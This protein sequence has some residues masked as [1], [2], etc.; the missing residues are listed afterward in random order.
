MKGISITDMA[1]NTKLNWSTK[2]NP[3]MIKAAI[4]TWGKLAPPTILRWNTPRFLSQIKLIATMAG[5][6]IRKLEQ[7]QHFKSIRE[8]S[9]KDNS[10]LTQLYC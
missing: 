6:I 10:T 2:S 5:N 3:Y 9:T 1:A 4:T 7:G 8:N